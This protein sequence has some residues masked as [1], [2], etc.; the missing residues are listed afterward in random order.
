MSTQH[1]R[2]P[3]ARMWTFL[4]IMCVIAFCAIVGLL[5]F[6]CTVPKVSAEARADL[7]HC[8]RGAHTDVDCMGRRGWFRS[9]ETRW[10]W[11]RAP[12]YAAERE[13]DTETRE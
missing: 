10:E 11:R 12:D 8:S 7:I 6:A 13:V 5:A 1:D 3:E 2:D 9:P 4:Q